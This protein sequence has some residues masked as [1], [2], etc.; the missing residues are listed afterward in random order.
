M[1]SFLHRKSDIGSKK[2]YSSCCIGTEV[3]SGREKPSVTP[4]IARSAMAVGA[5]AI[6]A[7]SVGAVALG[8][9]AIG[10]MVIGWFF[11]RR[12]RIDRLE[13]G[14]LKAGSIEIVEP[15]HLQGS[16]GSTES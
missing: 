14:T 10:R 1:K 8:T 5:L 7:L 9:V 4:A 2:G 12:G 11:V 16:N 13:I 15:L 6:G 3:L